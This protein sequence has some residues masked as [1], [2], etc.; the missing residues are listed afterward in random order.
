MKYNCRRAGITSPLQTL[1]PLLDGGAVQ[2]DSGVVHVEYCDKGYDTI[3]HRVT[4]EGKVS[5][6]WEG[7]G[8]LP[9]GGGDFTES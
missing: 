7:E 1:T 2:L 8:R 4:K 9:G 3:D 5:W 6:T